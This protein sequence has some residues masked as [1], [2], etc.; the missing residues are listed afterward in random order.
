LAR[1]ARITRL[2]RG[3]DKKTLSISYFWLMLLVAL[4]EHDRQLI[5]RSA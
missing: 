3:E 5:Q 1:F 2:L 4:T